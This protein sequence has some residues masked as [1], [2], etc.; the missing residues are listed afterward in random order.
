MHQDV[1]GKTAL[2]EKVGRDW[3][4]KV[5]RRKCFGAIQSTPAKIVLEPVLAVCCFPL[6]T[7]PAFPAGRVCHDNMISHVDFGHLRT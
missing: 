3:L 6:S 7:K 1:F 2:P 4:V 5:F